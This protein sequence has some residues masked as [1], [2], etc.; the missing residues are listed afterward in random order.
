MRN[1][2]LVKII[3]VI[4]TFCC[5]FSVF[6]TMMIGAAE[7]G[8]AGDPVSERVTV[9]S[10]NAAY[11]TK[12]QLVFALKCDDLA[13]NEEL[14]LLFWDK[15]PEAEGKTAEEL[16]KSASYRKTAYEEGAEVLGVEGCSLV[17]SKGIAADK[18]NTVFYVMPV[19]KAVSEN[20]GV[21]EFTYEKGAELFTYSVKQYAEEKLLD[22]EITEAQQTLCESLKKYGA[23]AEEYFAE[24]PS[25][26]SESSEEVGGEVVG[27]APAVSI[28]YK[29]VAYEDTVKLVFYVESANLADGQSVKLAMGDAESGKLFESVGKATVEGAEYDVFVSDGIEFVNLR[30]DVFAVAVVVDG[31]DEIVAQSDVLEYSVFDYCMDRIEKGSTAEQTELYTALLD[32]GAAV[33]AVKGYDNETVSALGGWANAYYGIKVDSLINGEVIESTKH[34]YT[35]AEVGTE[36]TVSVDKFVG[37]GSN[38]SIFSS[39]S[40]DKGMTVSASGTDVTLTVRGKI[41][42]STVSCDYVAG[43]GYCGFDDAKLPSFVTASKF[44]QV[45]TGETGIGEWICN[46]TLTGNS[47]L[48][49]EKKG[50]NNSNDFRLVMSSLET[51]GMTEYSVDFKIRWNGATAKATDDITILKYLNSDGVETKMSYMLKTTALNSDLIVGTETV[52]LGEWTSMRYVAIKTA[53]GVWTMQ[54]YVGDVLAQELNGVKS[55]SAPMVKFELRYGE[56]SLSMDFDDIFVSAK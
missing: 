47:Y 55:V 37:T 8:G 24:A 5:L 20:S 42:F 10:K 31:E 40:A 53:D 50:D 30:N 15:D 22:P 2:K 34:Y 13:E 51:E 33:Q 36:K 14:Y 49:V 35:E 4:L 1:S 44:N 7:A 21:T 46:D 48:H 54:T 26:Q 27:E 56:Y 11:D 18:I 16:Y 39:A 45:I 25:A 6:A 28:K 3:T 52:K 19:I 43:L 17:A 41:G 9:V 29:N 32:L 23:V 38:M 12:T